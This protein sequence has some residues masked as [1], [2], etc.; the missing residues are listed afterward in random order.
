LIACGGRDVLP[1]AGF[2]ILD[3]SGVGIDAGRDAGSDAGS[4]AGADAGAEV[5]TDAGPDRCADVSCTPSD[6]CHDSTCDPATGACV[7]REATDG[8]ACDDSDPCTASTCLAGACSGSD[9][10]V[11]GTPCP[12]GA[13]VAGACGLRDLGPTSPASGTATPISLVVHDTNAFIGNSYGGTTGDGSITSLPVAGGTPTALASGFTGYPHLTVVGGT[14]Y[15][16]QAASVWRVPADGSEAATTLHIGAG[17][18]YSGLTSDGVRLYLTSAD[19]GT[20]SSMPFAGGAPTTI[21]A[22]EA[23]PLEIITDGTQLYW[24]A[25]GDGTI[26]TAPVTG[27]SATTLVTGTAPRAL[28][29]DADN[30]YWTESTAGDVMQMAL[31]GGAPTTIATG[32]ADP[33]AIMLLGGRVYWTNYNGGVYGDVRS[34]PIGGG[35]AATVAGRPFAPAALAHDAACIYVLHAGNGSVS[36][37][38]AF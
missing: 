26:R 29:I 13:C 14:V 2:G 32:Q 1:D 18:H 15:Y 3:G 28:A 10:A 6:A 24:V 21:A 27:S 35:A 11:D 31:T 36:S 30:L 38:P 20:V 22:G 33:A 17:D 12:C 37:A 23:R 9:P 34:A 25:S 19:G 4:D 5:G 7:E 8:R 16:T